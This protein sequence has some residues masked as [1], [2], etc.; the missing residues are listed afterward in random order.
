MEK[1][2]LPNGMDVK[3]YPTPPE[4]FIA[5]NADKRTLK[6][7]GLPTKPTNEHHLKIWNRLA[8]KKLKFIKPTFA[9]KP[10]KK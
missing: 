6:L 4:D 5:A 2:T 10:L 9:L 3:L 1:I 8:N 7:C